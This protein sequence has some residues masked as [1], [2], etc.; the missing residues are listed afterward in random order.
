MA[1][2]QSDGTSKARRTSARRPEIDR[3]RATARARDGWTLEKCRRHLKNA[4]RAIRISE[5]GAN[6]RMKDE[7]SQAYIRN[8]YYMY[9]A[10]A[11][12][13]RISTYYT[14][15]PTPPLPTLAIGT[16]GIL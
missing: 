15:A 9:Y 1:N 13:G 14:R 7:E 10:M 11:F 3:W 6:Q 2:G 8:T 5:A 4:S 16:S 12:F